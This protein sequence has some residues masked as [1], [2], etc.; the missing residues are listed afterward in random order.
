MLWTYH[1][2]GTGDKISDSP[3]KSSEAQRLFSFA[4]KGRSEISG[5]L[6]RGFLDPIMPIKEDLESNVAATN[7]QR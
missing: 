1:K 3:G 2:Y 5:F 6:E 7:P 4:Q